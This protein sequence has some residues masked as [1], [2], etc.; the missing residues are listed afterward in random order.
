MPLFLTQTLYSLISNFPISLLNHSPLHFMVTAMVI[1]IPHEGNYV[2]LCL[3]SITWHNVLLVH[4]LQ[5][6]GLLPF[7]WLHDNP[8][9]TH[10]GNDFKARKYPFTEIVK[11]YSN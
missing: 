3:D 10:S 6:M 7:K 4:S 5:K 2:I 11:S 8:L 9:C 1:S